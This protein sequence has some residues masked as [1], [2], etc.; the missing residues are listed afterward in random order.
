M[1]NSKI[2]IFI[3]LTLLVLMMFIG[4]FINLNK[5]LERET[6]LPLVVPQVTTNVTAQVEKKAD[7]YEIQVKNLPTQKELSQEQVDQLLK[8]GT[9]VP[10]QVTTSTGEVT[11]STKNDSKLPEVKAS[12]DKEA[13]EKLQ[14]LSK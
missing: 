12:S 9:M 7:L 3:G 6:T 1:T 4:S 11:L 5:N 8:E 14:K 10:V 2:L 13:I